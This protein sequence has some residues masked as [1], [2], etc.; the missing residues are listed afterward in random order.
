MN[1][2]SKFINMTC[3]NYYENPVNIDNN[4][5]CTFNPI[6]FTLVVNN[7]KKDLLNVIK[8]NKII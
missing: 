1:T 2:N 8:N 4:K 3:D 6:L 5:L 7:K